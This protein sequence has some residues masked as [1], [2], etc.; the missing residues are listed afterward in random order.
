MAM[1]SSDDRHLDLDER[2]RAE[3]EAYVD[4]WEKFRALL[5]A[6]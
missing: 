5:A 2:A 6:R 1:D 4:E 3:A